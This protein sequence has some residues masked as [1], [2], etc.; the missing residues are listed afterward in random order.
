MRAGYVE[1]TVGH[2]ARVK[3]VRLS[4][5]G[6]ASVLAARRFRERLERRLL[7]KLGK[8]RAGALRQGLVE[9][10]DE[11]GGARAVRARRVPPPQSEH[12]A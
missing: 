10:L 1:T 9:L 4:D 3:L 12:E 8:R 7:A 6:H 2:D 5:R 11:L